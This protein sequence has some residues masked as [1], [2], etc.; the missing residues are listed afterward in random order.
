MALIELLQAQRELTLL[1]IIST[2]L[3]FLDLKVTCIGCHDILNR[4][5]V[6]PVLIDSNQ[7][8]ALQNNP[9]S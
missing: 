2:W 1:L 7:N 5:R 8:R 4:Y 3:W 6:E 9:P